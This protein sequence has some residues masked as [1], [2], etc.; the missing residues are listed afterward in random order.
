MEFLTGLWL[1]IVLSA[2]FVFI[3]SSVIHMALPIH[4][5]DYKKLNNEEGLL[6]A[7]RTAG[8]TPGCYMFPCAGSMK[9]MG[10][11]EMVAKLKQGPVGHMTVTPPGGCNI[12][13][14]LVWWFAYSLLIGVMVAYVTWNGLGA[15]AR[16]LDVFQIAGA[17]A[18]LGYAAGHFHDSIWKGVPWKITAK[19]I[20]DGAIYGLVTAGTFGWLWPA[21]T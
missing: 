14:S 7:M 8:V 2:V 6:A 9:E 13:T 11:P 4:K 20:F 3:V 10:S 1:P 12:G 21:A 15:G 16:Y 19:F 18:V 5:G 17:A